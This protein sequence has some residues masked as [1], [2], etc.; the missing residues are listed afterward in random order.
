LCA[1]SSQCNAITPC[2]KTRLYHLALLHCNKKPENVFEPNNTRSIDCFQKSLLS[3]EQNFLGVL[4]N[5]LYIYITGVDMFRLTRLKI[6]SVLTRV[7]VSICTQGSKTHVHC[8]VY[9]GKAKKYAMLH[10]CRPKAVKKLAIL[11]AYGRLLNL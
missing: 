6:N 4:N 5:L 2:T 9:C 11:P 3:I 10:A 8:L 1:F 7:H